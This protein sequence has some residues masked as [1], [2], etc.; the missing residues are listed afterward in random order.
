MCKAR[1]ID[2]HSWA[3]WPSS[4]SELSVKPNRL[5][6][7]MLTKQTGVSITSAYMRQLRT[8]IKANPS[9]PRRTGAK[10]CAGM[11]VLPDQPSDR[12]PARC[13]AEPPAGT[14]DSRVRQLAMRAVGPAPEAIDSSMDTVDGARQPQRLPATASPGGEF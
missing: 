11:P 3:G 2:P 12:P 8:Q 14:T 5:C 13:P 9:V 7:V 1:V 10:C 6:E 4:R